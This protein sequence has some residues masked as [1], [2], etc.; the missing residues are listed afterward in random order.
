MTAV[1]LDFTS[2]SQDTIHTHSNLEAVRSTHS[3]YQHVLGKRLE[4]TGEKMSSGSNLYLLDSTTSQKVAA[5]YL[6]NLSCAHP[7]ALIGCSTPSTPFEFVNE[8]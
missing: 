4:D 7:R 1:S 3:N 6:K 2:P 5:A 8:C